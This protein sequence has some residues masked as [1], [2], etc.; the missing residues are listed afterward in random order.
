[1]IERVWC[2]RPTQGRPRGA[3]EL[4]HTEVVGDVL[5]VVVLGYK[6]PF[7]EP[8][9]LGA[10]GTICPCGLT[11]AVDVASPLLGRGSLDARRTYTEL[12]DGSGRALY[13]DD[14][15]PLRRGDPQR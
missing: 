12:P 7:T 2:D 14:G 11:Y 4:A 6:E 10:V 9:P 13:D 15:T 3:H 5:H 1:M 8:P